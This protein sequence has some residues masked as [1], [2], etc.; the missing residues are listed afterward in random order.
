MK[1]IFTLLFAI[2]CSFSV[3]GQT[4][5][6]IHLQDNQTNT[7]FENIPKGL[8]EDSLMAFILKNRRRIE[9]KMPDKFVNSFL[10]N[11]NAGRDKNY[12]IDSIPEVAQLFINGLEFQNKN[13]LCKIDNFKITSIRK[14]SIYTFEVIKTNDSTGKL[15]YTNGK[16]KYHPPYAR[17]TQEH[18]NLAQNFFLFKINTLEPV[19]YRASSYS[20]VLDIFNTEE[21]IE[22]IVKPRVMI[23]GRLQAKSFDYDKINLDDIEKIDVFGS[24][25][26]VAY[27]GQK[28]KVGLISFITKGSKFGFDWELANTHVVGEIQ[29]N[30]GNWKKIVDTLFTN[31]N[32]FKEYRKSC[33][34]ANGA[35]Y[36][37]NGKFETESSNR[38]TINMDAISNLRVVSSTK[39]K[40]IPLI[41]SDKLISVKTET[42]T[43]DNDTIYIELNRDDRATSGTSNFSKIVSELKTLRNASSIPMPIYIV[44][45]QEIDSEKLK[46]Y[47]P[48]ELEF[49]ESL[50]GCDAISK[51]G[52]R[53]EFG[54]VIY[55]KK[56]IE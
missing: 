17:I 36:L 15:V 11:M 44:D 8:S 55:R 37:I 3:I 46:L 21:S 39:I 1:K 45:N 22:A 5:T 6:G 51:Y 43:A 26:A 24:S 40:R 2:C 7:F 56:K 28:G 42:T 9:A 31:I 52:K 48:K 13:V 10:D 29:D 23:D 18:Q 16:R 4:K 20:P 30:K 27:F 41:S 25:D 38:K 34:N 50:E 53:A 32:Q 33:L 35:I 49:V 54:V 12:T 47:K 19:R 14:D